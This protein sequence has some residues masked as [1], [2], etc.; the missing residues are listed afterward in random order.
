[1]EQ[2]YQ[3][4]QETLQHEATDVVKNT[5]MFLGNASCFSK[6]DE[7]FIKETIQNRLGGQDQVTKIVKKRLRDATGLVLQELAPETDRAALVRL[8]EQ[9][10]GENWKNKEN[11]LEGGVEL[12]SWHGVST[13]DSSDAVTELS[14]ADNNVLLIG[15]AIGFLQSLRKVDVS[16]NRELGGECTHRTLL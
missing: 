11:W 3:S 15:G 2:L 16:Y 13:S 12:S 14:L 8:F 7:A 1:M 6:N 5:E 10:D 9:S 4:D